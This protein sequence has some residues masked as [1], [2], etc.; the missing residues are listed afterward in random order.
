MSVNKIKHYL[1]IERK[2]RNHTLNNYLKK[3]HHE[4]LINV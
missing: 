2:K 1:Y 3:K 4:N